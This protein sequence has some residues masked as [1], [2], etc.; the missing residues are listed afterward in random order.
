MKT[1]I[2]IFTFGL[3]VLGFSVN[4]FAQVS[5]T[6]S[7]SGTIVSPIAITKTVDMN[8]GNVAVSSSPGTVILAPSGTRTPGGGVTLPATVGTVSA[9][10]FTVTG[11]ANYTYI[12]T[13]PLTAST[14]TSGGNTMTADSF[15][16]VPTPTG[17]LDGTGQQTLKVGATLNVGGGQAAGVY[18]T[19]NPFTVTVNYN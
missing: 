12:I 8:F 17:T 18:T 15:T 2:K 9:A 6:S 5:A 19:A 1:A 14:L 7:A 16:S 10:T 3:V 11:V 13:L 4:S